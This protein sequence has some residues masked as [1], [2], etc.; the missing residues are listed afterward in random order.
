MDMSRLALSETGRFNEWDC[1]LSGLPYLQRAKTR[2]AHPSKWGKGRDVIAISIARALQLE[3]DGSSAFSSAMNALKAVTG[4][5]PG[6]WNDRFWRTH[7]S[8]LRA[9][10]RAMEIEFRKR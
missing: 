7:A 2:I 5:N 9:F 3:N 10:D 1:G 6:K 4:G 8:V